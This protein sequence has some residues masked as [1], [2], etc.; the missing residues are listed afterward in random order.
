M[1][2]DEFITYIKLR[3][4][5]ASLAPAINVKIIDADRADKCRIGLQFLFL[6]QDTKRIIYPDI[7]PLHNQLN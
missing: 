3:I 6:W 5:Y 1:L 2:G 4:I 7:Y